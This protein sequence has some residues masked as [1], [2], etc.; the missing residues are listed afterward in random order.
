M[1]DAPIRILHVIDALE[2]G[3]LENGVIN[4]VQRMDAARFEHV[5]CAMRRVGDLADRIPRDRVKIFCLNHTAPGFSLQVG[6]LRRLIRSVQPDVVHSR[7]WG[8]MEAVIAGKSLPYC[9]VV[10]SEHGMETMGSSELSAVRRLFR[11]GIFELADQVLSVSY[12]LRETHARETGYRADRIEVI[13]N[14]VDAQRFRRDSTARQEMRRRLGISS[15][16]YCLGTVGR[17][18]PVKDIPTLLSAV[19][20]VADFLGDWCLLIA[21]VGSEFQSLNEYVI[22]DPVLQKHV[23]FLGDVR[24][25]PGFLNALDVYLL[26][27]IY[28]GISNSL[29]EALATGLPAI[30]TATGGNPE[31]IVDGDSGYLVPVRD[32]QAVADKLILLKQD[33]KLRRELGRQAEQRARADFS[34][35]SMVKKYADMYTGAVA[36]KK[37]HRPAKSAVL[38]GSHKHETLGNDSESRLA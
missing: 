21:G 14:G 17:I 1:A 2:V 30:V 38:S 33:D 29:L 23:R 28:E 11:R 26:P 5:L 16:C 24:D 9:S 4:L 32:P 25:V 20:K 27:S 22:G 34:L 15:D 10:H 36:R 12:Q 18:E 13:H 7:N 37:R 3:G 8:C 19:K 35:E 6:T 31:V